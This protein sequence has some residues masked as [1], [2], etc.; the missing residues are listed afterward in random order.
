ME[1]T[2]EEREYM[3][4]HNIGTREER[5]AKMKN[6]EES[7][8]LHQQCYLMDE[9]YYRRNLKNLFQF[10]DQ[11]DFRLRNKLLVED[12]ELIIQIQNELGR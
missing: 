9:I 6:W 1:Y 3:R 4:K 8:R 11:P 5:Y 10:C 2:P 12:L 7:D